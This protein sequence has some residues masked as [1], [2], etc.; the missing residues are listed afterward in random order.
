MRT[1]IFDLD[2]TL[3][4]SVKRKRSHF[5]VQVPSQTHAHADLTVKHLKVRPGAYELIGYC[6]EHHQVGVWSMGQPG[7]VAAVLPHLFPEQTLAFVY[8][9]THCYRDGPHI[10]KRLSRCPTP[11][12]TTQ[13]ID[14]RQDLIYEPDHCLPVVPYYGGAD[15]ADL[16]RILQLL[17]SSL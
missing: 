11:F 1:I 13:I 4:A 10:Y 9:W 16:Y 15:D 2:N 5:T 6:L 8:D 14:D 17:Q 3:L 7:Y 12:E